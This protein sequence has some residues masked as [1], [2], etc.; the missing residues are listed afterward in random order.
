MNNSNSKL[1]SQVAPSD[2]VHARAITHRAVQHLT[3]LARANI[4][5]KPDDS[6]SNLG[7]DSA[8]G[9]L[10][11]HAMGDVVM[12]LK[13][14]PLTLMILKNDTAVEEFP[15]QSKTVAQAVEWTDQ[16]AV[17]M[18]LSAAS[19]ATIPYDLPDDVAAISRY[20]TEIGAEQ[21][22]A[23]SEWFRLAAGVLETLV[24]AEAGQKPGPSPVR[25]WPHHFDIATYVALEEGD[26]E[27]AR[28]IGVGMSPGDEGHS[29]PYFY[30]NPWPHLDKASLPPATKP[31]YWHVE[32][33]VGL[34][35]TATSLQATGFIEGT[36]SDFITYGF[37][38]ALDARCGD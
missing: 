27:T 30:I 36:T 2:L 1:L 34:V 6:H 25:C 26:P 18:G 22:T 32:G 24:A 13:F 31:G 33:Y 4:E 20:E 9:G 16:V 12:A 5:A 35:A 3:G 28:G 19:T 38:T 29:E 8:I 10:R 21:I 23:L 15:L 17:S 7:W 37:K 11:T 14:S